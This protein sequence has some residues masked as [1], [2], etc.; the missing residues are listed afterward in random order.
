[1]L[2]LHN[3]CL[4]LGKTPGTMG[5]GAQLQDSQNDCVLENIKNNKYCASQKLVDRCQLA[6][7]HCTGMAQGMAACRL[8]ARLGQPRKHVMCQR[9]WPA[10]A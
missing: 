2:L 5:H 3:L 10:R 6:S 9:A 8:G 4:Q 1:M 7:T